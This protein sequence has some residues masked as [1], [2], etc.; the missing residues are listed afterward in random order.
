MKYVHVPFYFI[1]LNDNNQVR[2][3]DWSRADGSNTTWQTDIPDRS[4]LVKK[5]KRVQR[6]KRS[7][8]ADESLDME[9]RWGDDAIHQRL[10]HQRAQGYEEKKQRC[11][12]VSSP[13]N[14][15]QEVE[16]AYRHTDERSV[17][18]GGPHLRVRR[19]GSIASISSRRGARPESPAQSIAS[20][21]TPS[22][23]SPSVMRRGSRKETLSA[24]SAQHAAQSNCSVTPSR[25]ALCPPS[26]DEVSASSS[27]TLL[28]ASASQ[29][30]QSL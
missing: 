12:P 8:L 19:N 5:W 23:S 20:R 13:V 17:E 3:G 16:N 1:H 10:T 6:R 2:W 14:W 18:D 11:A 15:D 4:D 30:T 9:V 29:A 28:D 22:Q 25:L 24:S 27:C 7:L 26:S 21:D